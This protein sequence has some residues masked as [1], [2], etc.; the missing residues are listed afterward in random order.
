MKYEEEEVLLSIDE[1]AVG[2][3]I[4]MTKEKWYGMV[5]RG[6]DWIIWRR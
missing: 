2:I 4:R 1:I 3:I 6:R 5:G